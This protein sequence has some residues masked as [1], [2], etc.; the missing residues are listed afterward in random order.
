MFCGWR[1]SDNASVVDSR[2]EPQFATC[3]DNNEVFSGRLRSNSSLN[4]EIGRGD[5]RE[6]DQNPIVVTWDPNEAVI[7]GGREVGKI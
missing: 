3:E 1:L 2:H 7:E 5:S 4:G 6:N